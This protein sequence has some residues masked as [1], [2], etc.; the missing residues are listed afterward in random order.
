MDDFDI[1]MPLTVDSIDALIDRIEVQM[2]L[3]L[4]HRKRNKSSESKNSSNTWNISVDKKRSGKQTKNKQIH[5]LYYYKVVAVVGSRLY[6]IYDGTTR[7]EI[8]K[9][10]KKPLISNLK[11]GFFVHETAEQAIHSGFPMNAKLT[12]VARA[13]I[14]VKCDGNVRYHPGD[15]LEVEKIFPI[16]VVTL[17]PF[18]STKPNYP[19]F[20]SLLE[21]MKFQASNAIDSESL[22]EIERTE[23]D[24]MIENL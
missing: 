23:M 20:N 16:E 17:L 12:E 2:L 18:K 11:S 3:A 9:W 14:R 24:K 1:S 4:V 6:S 7:Y 22:Q 5:R 13:L 8:N 15:C 21:H 19:M 10:I